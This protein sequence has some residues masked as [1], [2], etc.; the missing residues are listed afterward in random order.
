M[1]R[2]NPEWKTL[3]YFSAVISAVVF[4]SSCRCTT[5]PSNP[6]TLADTSSTVDGQKVTTVNPGDAD[7]AIAYYGETL[8]EL[9]LNPKNLSAGQLVISM[10]LSQVMA[11]LGY[12][13]LDLKDV[14]DLPSAELMK[15]F[16]G[17]VLSS[18]F[19]APKITDVSV[20][21]IN[22]GWRKLVRFKAKGEALKTGISAGYL[23]FNKFQFSDKFQPDY[24]KDPFGDKSKESL[25]T[26]LILVRAEGSALKYPIYF[27][28]FYRRSGGSRL[29]TFLTATFDARAP[30]IVPKNRYYVPNACAACHGG[31]TGEILKPDYEKLKL[32]YLDTDHW[33]DRLEDDFAILKD[34]TCGGTKKPCAVLYDARNDESEFEQAF[35]VLRELNREIEAQNKSV[36]P[37]GSFQL[38]AVTKWLQLHGTDSGHKDVFARA[39]PP[40]G[41]GDPWKADNPT[42]KELLPLLNRYCF[43]CHSSLKFNIFDRPAVARRKKD[44][45]ENMTRLLTDEKK[46]PQDRNLDCS[47]ETL[48]HKEKILE[49]V[50]LFPGPTPSPSAKPSP[51]CPAPTP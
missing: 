3:A 17:D 42:D 46:M 7:S 28:V 12:P 20:Q 41:A 43:R 35:N 48:A 9:G 2:T 13:N 51:T 47:A 29:I 1:Q 21:P 40:A 19:F 15:R 50:R 22:P 6:N 33:F 5:E 30:N 14:E 32:N 31:L 45:L 36:P 27:S 44:I 10:R 37:D 49:L 24:D 4:F 16:P 8:T 34:H 11:Y 38:R 25:N 39:L 26:Q 18:A 23:L